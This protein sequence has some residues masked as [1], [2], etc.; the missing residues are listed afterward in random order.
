LQNPIDRASHP[1]GHARHTSSERLLV[2]GLDE[3]V[4][5]VA[6]HREVY[7]AKPGPSRPRESAANGGKDRLSAQIRQG[8]FGSQ[9]HV[10]RVPSMVRRAFPVARR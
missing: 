9:R 7:Q 10:D 1:N 4:H 2:V 3:K 8:A 5:V 6:L